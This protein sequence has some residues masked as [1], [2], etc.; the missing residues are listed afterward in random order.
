MTRARAGCG[1]FE[2]KSKLDG[3]DGGLPDLKQ[4]KRRQAASPFEVA[5]RSGRE[6]AKNENEL[7]G[8]PEAKASRSGFLADRKFS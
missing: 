2:T 3:P 4:K 5:R 6:L 7:A 8:G 1:V